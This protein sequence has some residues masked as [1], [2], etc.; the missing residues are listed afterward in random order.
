MVEIAF[1][2][3]QNHISVNISALNPTI[4]IH[5]RDH[6]KFSRERNLNWFSNFF[7]DSPKHGWPFLGPI[8]I[9]SCAQE[10]SLYIFD[11]NSFRAETGKSWNRARNGSYTGKCAPFLNFL[12]L[13]LLC[14]GEFFVVTLPK[15]ILASFFCEKLFSLSFQLIFSFKGTKTWR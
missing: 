4:N 5:P 3:F 15:N 12:S 10:L 13:V 1:R 7:N 9:K 6:L 11:L 8:R 14:S 2:D